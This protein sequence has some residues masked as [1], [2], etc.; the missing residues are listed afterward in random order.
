MA[1]ILKSHLLDFTLLNMLESSW[2]RWHASLEY[3]YESLKKKIGV[4]KVCGRAITL[5]FLKNLYDLQLF[6]FVPSC[7]CFSKP[8][9]VTHL[10]ISHGAQWYV[11]LFN[12][13]KFEEYTCRVSLWTLH[14]A[15]KQRLVPVG[16]KLVNYP[17]NPTSLTSFG[18]YEP[19]LSSCKVWGNVC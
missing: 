13:T 5:F 16:P 11:Y 19:L 6:F 10:E 8:R 15:P 1:S 9:W 12:D 18:R 4:W 7:P 3:A 17:Q 14:W 2:K